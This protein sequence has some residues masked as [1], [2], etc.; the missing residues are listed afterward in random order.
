M[1]GYVYILASR[2]VGTLYVGV[3]SDIVKRVGE[4]KTDVVK[5][6]TSKYNIKMLVYYEIHDEIENAIHREKCIKEWKR[7]WKIQLIEKENPDWD[8][9]YPKIANL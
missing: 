9:L 8:D 1:P 5:G 3:T 4:H 6:F 2:K 7:A